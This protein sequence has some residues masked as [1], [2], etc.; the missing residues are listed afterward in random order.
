MAYVALPG[1]IIKV[2]AGF[3]TVT[4]TA[5]VSS[6]AIDSNSGNDRATVVSTVPACVIPKLRG[7]RLKGAKKALR[8]AHC[9][10]G[11]V[12]HRYSRKIRK[13]RVVR[14]GRHRGTVLPVGSKVKPSVSRGAK[15]KG[16][17][18]SK[19]AH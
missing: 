2:T 9:K 14:V 4:N 17:H 16:H 19:G 8:V 3:G 12:T 10:P 11:K 1:L 13:D 6:Q 7:R 15:H 18:R 5:T